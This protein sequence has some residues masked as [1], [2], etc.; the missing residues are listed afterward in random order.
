MLR[1]A[2]NP[3]VINTSLSMRLRRLVVVIALSAFPAAAA[4]NPLL[5]L[6]TAAR[7]GDVDALQQAL[8]DGASVNGVDPDFGQTALI[9]AAMF[10]QR[11]AAEA[12]LT[13][14]ADPNTSSNLSRTALHWAAVSGAADV[15]ALLLRAGAR[16]EAPDAYGETPLGYA[17]EAGQPAAARALLAGGARVDKMT[18]PLAP[19]LSLVLGNGVSG[20]PLDVLV[21]LIESRQGLEVRDDINQRTPLLVAGEYGYRDHS[22]AVAAALVRAGAD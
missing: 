12:L 22:A 5:D 11:A 13:A 16:V 17:A 18:K 19:R 10:G 4:A 20:P 21:A 8:A 14:K 6:L 7:H 15:I 9:R 2:R 3:L 1:V